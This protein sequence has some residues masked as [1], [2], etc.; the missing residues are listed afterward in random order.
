MAVFPIRKFGDPILKEKCQPVEKITAEVKQT[1]KNLADSMCHALGVGLAACQIG[2]LSRIIVLDIGEG[3]EVYINPEII[4]Q[5]KKVEAM[6]EGCLSFPNVRILVTRS[7][8]LKI[9]ALDVKGNEFTV[10]ASDMRGH[11][12]QHEIDHLDG[13]L[14][15]D[16]ADKNERRKA[17]EQFGGLIGPHIS[18]PD[19]NIL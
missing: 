17:L 8:S 2:V 9:K 5:S 7:V 14:L 13:I 15:I 16:R 11:A 19:K 1:V 18:L 12:L 3:L 6:D 4:D 10:N